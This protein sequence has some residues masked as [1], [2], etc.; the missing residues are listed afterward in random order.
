MSIEKLKSIVLNI[1]QNDELLTGEYVPD[2]ILEF[3]E[4]DINAK[5]LDHNI[6]YYFIIFHNTV[7]FKIN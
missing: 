3:F 2:E 4:L 7:I 5:Y 6:L 1:L